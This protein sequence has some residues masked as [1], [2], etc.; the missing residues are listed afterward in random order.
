[1]SLS[2]ARREASLYWSVDWFGALT[3]EDHSDGVDSVRL[4]HVRITVDR[5]VL[6]QVVLVCVDLRGTAVWWWRGG[7]WCR[8]TAR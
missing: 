2:G 5:V 4:V 7:V 3:H 8:V 1:M 6:L